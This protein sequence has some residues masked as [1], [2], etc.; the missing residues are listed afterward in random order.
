[1]HFHCG[2]G[3]V[4]GGGGGG[5]RE[6]AEYER[7]LCAGKQTGS[8]MVEKKKKKTIQYININSS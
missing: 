4:G 3:G 2:G 1:M 8:H 7:G 5:G 6:G